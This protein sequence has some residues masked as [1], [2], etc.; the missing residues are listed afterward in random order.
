VKTCAIYPRGSHLE[1]VAEENHRDSWRMTA[2]C[3]KGMGSFPYSLL[4]VGPGAHP[5]VQAVS[6]Q[7]AG[8][9]KSSIR[10]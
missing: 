3:K 5:G 6:P 7:D 2:V 1:Q 8:D 10:R 9:Y 4:S